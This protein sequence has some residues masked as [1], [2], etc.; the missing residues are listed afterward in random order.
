MLMIKTQ[1]L[2]LRKPNH[3]SKTTGFPTV[4][5]MLIGT[6]VLE[7]LSTGRTKPSCFL[8]CVSTDNSYFYHTYT[9]LVSLSVEKKTP[10]HFQGTF[11]KLACE[12][13]GSHVVETCWRQA[14][15]KHKEAITQELALS[16]QQL[17]S[18]FYGRI[19]LKNCGVE[20]FKRK[21]KT[22]HEKEQKAARKRKLIEEI[23]E[24]REDS[25]KQ[26]KKAK[27]KDD[28]TLTNLAP[29]MAALGFTASGRHAAD[30]EGV[31]TAG[32]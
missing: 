8:T 5:V 25:A 26:N 17:T 11:V 28:Q 4:H 19:V 7:T 3:T 21:D 16:E 1:I 12:K 29:E 31:R 23:L 27:L 32:N 30:S 20:H 9:Y 22:W 24:E 18:N 14:E 13:Q 6:R 10:L 15:V 2:G